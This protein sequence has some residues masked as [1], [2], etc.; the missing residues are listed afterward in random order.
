MKSKGLNILD[1]IVALVGLGIIVTELCIKRTE[2]HF[3]FAA[4]VLYIVGVL[5][6]LEY[7]RGK[8]HKV[9]RADRH[10]DPVK[11]WGRIAMLSILIL[12]G[13]ILGYYGSKG[14]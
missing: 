3:E 13:A 2:S 4:P 7:R 6:Y 8:N 12:I 11:A 1:L 9:R 5:G 14:N 10:I